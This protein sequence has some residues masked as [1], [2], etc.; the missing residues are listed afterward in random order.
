MMFTPKPTFPARLAF[1]KAGLGSQEPA[2]VIVRSFKAVQLVT[3]DDLLEPGGAFLRLPT[4]LS[5]TFL[6]DFWPDLRP[7]SLAQHLGE[8][9]EF[10]SAQL[11]DGT[12]SALPPLASFRVAW[13]MLSEGLSAKDAMDRARAISATLLEQHKQLRESVD[14]LVG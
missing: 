6:G 9:E 1:L 8:L 14:R 2:L 11:K 5:D 10:L 12:P 3:L 7:V 13:C 4:S